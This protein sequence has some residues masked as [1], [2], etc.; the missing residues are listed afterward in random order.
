MNRL[1]SLENEFRGYV[2]GL[3]RCKVAEKD[4][5]PLMARVLELRFDTAH[6]DPSRRKREEDRLARFRGD[7]FRL[8]DG[9]SRELGRNAYAVFNALTEYTSNPEER[10]FP[11]V[12]MDAMQRRVGKWAAAYPAEASVWRFRLRDYTAE[13]QAYFN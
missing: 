6:R 4:M 3:L 5:L 7:A 9:Y 11:A 12:R 10:A 8:A 2:T 13:Y 1:K